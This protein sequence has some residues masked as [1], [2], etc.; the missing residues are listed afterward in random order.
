MLCLLNVLDNDACSLNEVNNN[1]LIYIKVKNRFHGHVDVYCIILFITYFYAVCKI[2]DLCACVSCRWPL[3]VTINNPCLSILNTNAS[4]FLPFWQQITNRAD[5]K[6]DHSHAIKNS[7]AF[8]RKKT[9][10]AKE[11]NL[12]TIKT[13]FDH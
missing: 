8:T 12:Q 4:A 5:D 2:I 9:L 3:K 11:T 7:P 1:V 6:G 13:H 10:L